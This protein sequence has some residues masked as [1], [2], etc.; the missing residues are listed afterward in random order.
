METPSPPYPAIDLSTHLYYQLAYTL[1][2][3]LPPP[4][5]NSPE[6]LRIRNHTAIAKVAA[7]LP[8]NANKADL[9]APCI[10]AR[11]QS[12]D[13]LRL[14][15]QHADDIGLVMRL[16]AQR[17]DGAHVAVRAW[18][19]DAG[20]GGAPEAG[21]D[22]GRRDRRRPGSAYGRAVYAGGG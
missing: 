19:S 13:V 9:A 20:A 7:L 5:D 21:S 8:V 22:R 6:A 1:T 14:L 3:L 18:T 17:I 12:E 16:S 4:F 2:G 15:R 10:A 11:T